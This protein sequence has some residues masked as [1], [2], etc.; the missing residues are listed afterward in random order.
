MLIFLRW[1]HQRAPVLIWP[2]NIFMKSYNNCTRNSRPVLFANV[3]QQTHQSWTELKAVKSSDQF[4]V[5]HS[6]F[7]SRTEHPLPQRPAELNRP[8]QG[9]IH[10]K[11]SIL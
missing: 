2:A 3:G 11:R 9:E 5:S 4:S 10:S 1:S 6:P 8:G 7:I